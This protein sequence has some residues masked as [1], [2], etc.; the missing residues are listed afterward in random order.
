[1][2][3][4]RRQE[5]TAVEFKLHNWRRALAQARDHRLGADY[6]YVCMPT[7]PVSEQMRSEF[8]RLGIGLFWFT[9]EGSWPFETM[10]A[11]PRS[12]EAVEVIR[13]AFRGRISAKKGNAAWAKDVHP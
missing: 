13:A 9:S 10:L 3:Y 1:L 6:A 2:A 7:R 4:V 8:K 12:E 5:I 11:A